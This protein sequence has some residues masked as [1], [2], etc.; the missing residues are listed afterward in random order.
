MAKRSRLTTDCLSAKL[1]Y[2]KTRDGVMAKTS[3]YGPPISAHRFGL[4]P[5]LAIIIIINI[6]LSCLQMRVEC[7]SLIDASAAPTFA[8]HALTESADNIDCRDAVIRFDEPCR[9]YRLQ[10]NPA[11]MFLLSEARPFL[12]D[13]DNVAFQFFPPMPFNVSIYLASYRKIGYQ[14]LPTELFRGRNSDLRGLDL[15]SNHLL[16]ITTSSLSGLETSL[17]FL[18]LSD[19]SLGRN[20][21]P[22]LDIPEIH[23]LK[24]LKVLDLS[25]NGIKLISEQFFS[26]LTE[27]LEEIYLSKNDLTDIRFLGAAQNLA[28]LRILDLSNNRIFRLESLGFSTLPALQFLNLENNFLSM[29]LPSAFNGTS[30]KEINLKRNRMEAIDNSVLSGLERTLMKIDFAF[31]VIKNLPDLRSF[32]VLEDL[33]ISSNVLQNFNEPPMLPQSIQILDLSGNHLTQRS[34]PQLPLLPALRQLSLARNFLGNFFNLPSIASTFTFPLLEHLDIRAANLSAVPTPVFSLLPRLR[35]VDLCHNFFPQLSGSSFSN[36]SSLLQN[37]SLSH[38][39]IKSVAPETWQ[40][41]P[42][43]LSLDLSSNFLS[44][45]TDLTSLPK[46]LR[47]LN[48]AKNKLSTLPDLQTSLPNLI[49]L[50]VSGNNLSLV[51]LNLFP[52]STL[53][54]LN[55]SGNV[56]TAI[57]AFAENNSS[58]VPAGFGGVLGWMMNAGLQGSGNGKRR[59]VL[60]VLDLSWNRIDAVERPLTGMPNLTE[61]RLCG[62]RI[63][64]LPMEFLKDHAQ[65]RRVRLSRNALTGLANST[66]VNLPQLEVLDLSFNKLKVFPSFALEDVPRLQTLI[67]D[68][69]RLST[70]SP[71]NALGQFGNLSLV[72]LAKNDLNEISAEAFNGSSIQTLDLGENH[73]TRLNSSSFGSMPRLRTLRLASNNITYLG[74][75]V[76]S[77]VPQLQELDLSRNNLRKVPEDL[78]RGVRRLSL[79][80]SGNKLDS[81]PWELFGKARVDRL[82]SLNLAR[83]RLNGFPDKTLSEQDYNLISLSLAGNQI[84]DIPPGSLIS[85]KNVDLSF[86]PLSDQAVQTVLSDPKTTF[87]LSMAGVGMTFFP[88]LQ[89]QFLTHVNLSGNRLTSFGDPLNWQRASLLESVDLSGNQ[90]TDMRDSKL[91]WVLPKL[92][93]LKW[94]DLSGNSL[95][96]IRENELSG[97]IN[98]DYLD[99]SSLP[100]LETFDIS[101]LLEFPRLRTLKAASYPRLAN[102]PIGDISSQLPALRSITLELKYPILT[103]QLQGMLTPSIEGLSLTGPIVTRVT[104]DTFGAFNPGENFHLQLDNLGMNSLPA[105]IFQRFPRSTHLA[106]DVRNTHLAGMDIAGLVQNLDFLDGAQFT[107]LGNKIDCSCNS[108]TALTVW[109][110]VRESVRDVQCDTPLEMNGQSVLELDLT[111]LPCQRPLEGGAA[112][113][114]PA[115]TRGSMVRPQQFSQFNQLTNEDVDFPA[116]TRPESDIIFE[117][118]TAKPSLTQPQGRQST[119]LNLEGAIAGIVVGLL[120]LTAI[121]IGAIIFWFRRERSRQAQN[122]N[123]PVKEYIARDAPYA[124]IQN[125]DVV[126]HPTWYPPPQPV[127]V[128]GARNTPTKEPSCGVPPGYPSYNESGYFERGLYDVP[129]PDAR[130]ENA[131]RVMD[132]DFSD[133]ARTSYAGK[134]I[135]DEETK[136][137]RGSQDSF[138]AESCDMTFTFE[139]VFTPSSGKDEGAPAVGDVKAE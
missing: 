67:L 88:P 21:Q 68:S 114:L 95:K 101:N 47:K 32:A 133:Y 99:V 48:I 75:G 125:T 2:K 74:A 94:L 57:P 12:L 56:L 81:L 138:A 65:L 120:L 22:L 110:S 16:S 27:T 100:N 44:K 103:S 117:I 76:F 102:F 72:S 38:C 20:F 62:N 109:M 92:A 98:V 129:F 30:L 1:F 83:N 59:T 96:V 42:N 71:K 111:D 37:M 79:D 93:F 127:L 136:D 122:P 34:I 9:C 106:L 43:L 118:T 5:P 50:D 126:P 119:T 19:N 97:L 14:G 121:M 61:L 6:I 58:A 18:N 60:E 66:F 113:I 131:S 13:C 46:S 116:T 86:N 41:L 105:N 7:V 90:L 87:K 78:F 84:T 77:L 54:E 35:R 45:E 51:E 135:F 89:L 70:F 33:N 139:D 4:L 40:I 17:E 23:R 64:E 104:R 85:T 82:E 8:L 108:T 53:K 28:H 80:L 137:E 91:L 24:A 39:R 29:I 107:F 49:Q 36:A 52:L 134:S 123:E 73:L 15:S 11:T 31:N 128:L 69:N 63:A 124:V 25:S 10:K 26:G 115:P 55:F 130:S 3:S 112:P 132:G